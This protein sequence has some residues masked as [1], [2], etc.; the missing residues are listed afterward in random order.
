LKRFAGVN[1]LT[2][3]LLALIG[4]TACGTEAAPGTS[5]D[6]IVLV[7]IDTLRA[8]HL[9]G[10]GYPVETAPF[11]ESL[12]GAGTSF[13]RAFAHSST[14]G[15]SH[16]SM[17]TALYPIQHGVRTNGHVL[18]ESY[19]TL[20][21]V[22]ND[23]GFSTAAFV[24][25]NSHF[26]GSQ[27]A[28]GFDL[29]DQPSRSVLNTAGRSKPYRQAKD[30]TDA[31]LDWLTTSGADGELFLWVHYYDPHMPFLM[32]DTYVEEATP[33]DEASLQEF[34]EFQTDEHHATI[35]SGSEL[36][37]IH[38]YDAEIMYVDDQIKRLYETISELGLNSNTLWI[39]TS[40]HGQGL[41]N[42]GHFGHHE[43]I[44]NVHLH[45]PLIF[46]FSDNAP[47]GGE[48]E[49]QIVEQVDIPTTVLDLL[50]LEMRGQSEPMQGVSLVPML[51]GEPGYRHKQY[52]FA[53]R[54]RSLEERPSREPGE[55]YA[56]QSMRSKYL[57][58][59]EGPDEFYD[60]VRDPYETENLIDAAIDEKDELRST[61]E[62]I[63][64]TLRTDRDAN[65]VDEETLRRLRSLGYI[66]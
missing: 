33:G 47:A 11:L 56:L 45:V 54:R 18:D 61:L 9:P 25:G 20:A 19:V 60:L 12:A 17:F 62:S 23:S 37:R 52:A 53:E 7:T 65:V 15:P 13:K 1:R 58:F 2:V 34:L 28:Q 29:L 64:E 43:Q 36:R 57:W 8:D 5:L 16:A 40:D 3:A 48:I 63:V 32:P 31:V 6:R 50:G 26:E 22:L 10:F 51:V 39:I 14:T 55:R 24:S 44:Y 4:T 35:G 59:T 66:Q 49:D 38:M 42:H 46:H 21:E 27:I 41:A 30:T